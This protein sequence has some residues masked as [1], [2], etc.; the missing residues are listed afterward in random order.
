V[1]GSD[2]RLAQQLRAITYL[3]A[4]DVLLTVTMSEVQ[5][6]MQFKFTAAFGEPQVVQG[7]P[8]VPTLHEM[9]NVIRRMIFGF[10]DKGLCA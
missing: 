3:K 6:K 4:G 7:R 9:M 10:A 5:K 8:I 1:P 2:R